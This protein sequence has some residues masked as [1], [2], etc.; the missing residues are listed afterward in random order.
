MPS[1]VSACGR[2][3][4]LQRSA[5]GS[6]AFCVGASLVLTLF[7]VQ[8]SLRCGRLA[9]V[10]IPDDV[11]SLASGAHWLHLADQHGILAILR[12]YWF[13][14]PHSPYSTIA[15]TVGF[16]FFGVHDWAPYATSAIHVFFVMA[17]C[18][19]LLRG[20]GGWQRYAALSIA[21]TTPFLGASIYEFKGD[22]ASCF[23]VA[24]ALVMLL[25]RP[26]LHARLRHQAGTGALIGAA[27]L[28][29]PSI[30]APAI[31]MLG[32]GFAGVLIADWRTNRRLP[33]LRMIFWSI[34]TTSAATLAVAGPHFFVAGR[35]LW[36]YMYDNIFGANKSLWTVDVG[37]RRHLL[38]FLTDPGSGQS[39]L[40]IHFFIFAILILIGAAHMF[41]FGSRRA[42]IRSA[43]MSLVLLAAYLIP[44]ANAVKNHL[45]GLTFQCLLL[46]L[47]MQT[48]RRLTLFQPRLGRFGAAGWSGLL[49]ALTVASVATMGP[50]TDWVPMKAHPGAADPAERTRV[51]EGI[52]DRML[53]H[54][55]HKLDQ[56]TRVGLFSGVGDVTYGLVKLRAAQRGVSVRP[57]LVHNATSVRDFEP[58][59]KSCDLVLASE[60][61]T[62]CVLEW[63]PASKL[64]DAVLA[65]MMSDPAF[66]PI[67][68]FFVAPSGK[69]FVLFQR[70]TA[71]PQP[72]P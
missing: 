34:A 9:L 23:L 26:Y 4:F 62:G 33:R 67:A 38:F 31:L 13:D 40:G 30:F 8:A 29:K 71:K 21:G 47:A 11:G 20:I 51:A 72:S 58:V 35:R 57:Y 46:F 50:H 16:A 17:F 1:L 53:A 7:M 43:S 66:E 18:N 12:S 63:H 6:W 39:M 2:G 10:P 49:I 64:Q 14:P 68:H 69:R 59:L 48:I 41:C 27:L 22:Y 61:G 5:R 25:R 32:T 56:P 54:A 19:V 37:L 65:R 3:R 60:S 15:A 24:A 36:A 52:I 45:F 55:S 28:C 42:R 44:T 70:K